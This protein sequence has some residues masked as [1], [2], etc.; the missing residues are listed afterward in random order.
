MDTLH[1]QEYYENNLSEAEMFEY[2]QEIAVP[3]WEAHT[4]SR[5]CDGGHGSHD[6]G[7]FNAEWLKNR[8]IDPMSASISTIA[9]A[10]L[11]LYMPIDPEGPV[12]WQIRPEFETRKSIWWAPNRDD[13]SNTEFPWIKMGEYDVDILVGYTAEYSMPT[14]EGFYAEAVT[15]WKHPHKEPVKGSQYDE[16]AER[17]GY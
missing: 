8:D 17:M 7:F 15:V 5:D 3:F 14:D 13:A 4:S 9:R 16:Y 10:F 12:S 1:T 2:A 11:S 6:S